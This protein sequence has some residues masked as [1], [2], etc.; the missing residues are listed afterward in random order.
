MVENELT[1]VALDALLLQ[2]VVLCL[3]LA[4]AL[5]LLLG[6]TAVDFLIFF[7]IEHVLKY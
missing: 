1:L 5:R 4:L 6:A 3:Q 7:K 2:L